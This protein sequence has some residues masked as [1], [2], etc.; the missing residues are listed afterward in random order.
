MDAAAQ[1]INMLQQ[2]PYFLKLLINNQ[3]AGAILGRGGEG[4]KQ[5]ESDHN[6][7]IRVSTIDS[8]FPGTQD[9][10]CLMAGE[11]EGMLG[12][13]PLMVAKVRGEEE[14]ADKP[15]VVKLLATN[16]G[17][18]ALIGKA[19]AVSKEL[20]QA[21][22]A[23]LSIAE[24]NGVV[25]DRI[26]SVTGNFEQ[27]VKIISKMLDKLQE[28]SINTN[29]TY[30][31]PTGKNGGSLMSQ[32]VGIWIEVSEGEVPGLIGKGGSN[33]KAITAESGAKLHVDDAT[34]GKCAIHIQGSLAQVHHAH[35][36]LV[37]QIRDPI[38]GNGQDDTKGKGK[39]K[40]KGSTRASPY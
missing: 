12:A 4:Q 35:S 39:G 25:R 16:D 34:D 18:G 6:V 40:G 15:G 38:I 5:M 28:G 31:V 20:M 8:T 19:G 13:V 10:V 14:S 17:C 24:S 36:A 21:T 26:V 30:S 1:R 23:S 9:R 11:Q 29:V 22:G 27:V 33:I 7:A 2:G 32:Q 37:E 3:A